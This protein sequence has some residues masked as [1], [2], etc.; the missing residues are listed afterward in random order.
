MGN[1]WFDA[2]NSVN[3]LRNLSKDGRNFK[4]WRLPTLFE[5]DEMYA[6]RL[7]IGNLGAHYWGGF[8]NTSTKAYFFNF[9]NGNNDYASK[10]NTFKVRRVRAF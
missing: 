3:T 6:A 7:G 9:F 2:L 1:I 4:D 8:E 10:P 5:L